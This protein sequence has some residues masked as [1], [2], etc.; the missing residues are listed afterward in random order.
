MFNRIIPSE[1]MNRSWAAVIVAAVGIGTTVAANARAKKLSKQ[2]KA[3]KTPEEYGR[4]QEFTE[5]Y[6]QQGYDPITLNYLNNQVDR[7]FSST[8]GTATRLGGDA[9]DLSA[10]FDKKMQS[11]MQIG[12][13][14]HALNMDNFSKYLSALDIMGQNEAAEQLSKDNILKD[15]LQAVA[16]KKQEG[17]GLVNAGLSIYS[18]NQTSGLYKSK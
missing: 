4:I 15:R 9:N 5:A 1:L 7:T 6:A 8:I 18:S 12:A 13:Q 14:N 10:I 16:A 3:Y 2:R 17:M 11:I